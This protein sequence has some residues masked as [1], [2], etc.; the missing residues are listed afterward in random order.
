MVN[1]DFCKC[2]DV[3]LGVLPRKIED[4][5]VGD[6]I[7]LNRDVGTDLNYFVYLGEFFIEY[8][9]LFNIV[10]KEILIIPHSKLAD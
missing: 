6:I 5:N 1:V 8:Y 4:L 2:K 9:L 3:G 10:T 7:R